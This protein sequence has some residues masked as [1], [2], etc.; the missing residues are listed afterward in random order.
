MRAVLATAQ[1][2]AGSRYWRK[3]QVYS[4][5]TANLDSYPVP[6][7]FRL[8]WCDGETELVVKK[9]SNED[10]KALDAGYSRRFI[11]TKTYGTGSLNNV[12]PLQAILKKEMGMKKVQMNVYT[13]GSDGN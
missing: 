1:K 13:G 8:F 6:D 2:L 9:Q 4:S 12:P 10:A 5:K 11:Q 3:T 7:S